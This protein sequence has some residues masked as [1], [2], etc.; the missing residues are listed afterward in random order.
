MLE[1]E[2][3]LESLVDA[4]ADI[5]DKQQAL[6]RKLIDDAKQRPNERPLNQFV[7]DGICGRADQPSVSGGT[8]VEI[9]IPAN[10]VV[11][12]KDI[13]DQIN[14]KIRRA[15]QSCRSDILS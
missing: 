13:V 12:A 11:D 6:I 2:E 8:T 14:K 15:T 1:R 7:K 4:Y 10:N 9:C 5:C 3:Y